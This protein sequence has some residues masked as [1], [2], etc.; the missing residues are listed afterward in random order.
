MKALPGRI[1]SYTEADIQRLVN[2]WKT[3]A[4]P[5][6]VRRRYGVLQAIFAFAVASKWLA[7]SPCQGIR[8]PTSTSTRRRKLT[9]G[10]VVAIAG[11]TDQ[12]YQAMVWIG[13]VLGMRWS[14]VA[15]LRVGALDLLKRAVSIADGGTIIRDIKGRPVTSD[16]KSVASHAMLP[17]PAELLD[18][19]AE[20]LARQNLNAADNDQL[21]FQAPA[22]GPLRYSNWRNRVWLPA[23]AAAGWDGAGFHD[24]RRANA[25]ALVR[26]GVDIRTAQA[27]LRHS[28]ARLT[29]NLYAQ[30]K[31][32]AERNAT[33]QMAARFLR[34]RDKREMSRS[35]KADRRGRNS[36]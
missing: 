16:P 26:D 12:R 8:L 15:G 27:L 22:G 18:I 7:Q 23:V 17:I 2:T 25:T 30:A 20:H 4:K 1:G 5:R 28:D 33:D 6:T 3:K 32:E 9:D 11:A 21:V 31:A 35:R 36:L 19:L 14:E 10:E 24:L 29:L 13:A 34:P